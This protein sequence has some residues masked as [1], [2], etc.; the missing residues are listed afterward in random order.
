LRHRGYDAVS[1]DTKL[2]QAGK[3]VTGSTT[4]DGNEVRKVEIELTGEACHAAVGSLNYPSKP[5]HTGPMVVTQFFWSGSIYAASPVSVDIS[6]GPD[7]ARANY[8]PAAVLWAVQAENLSFSG[9]PPFPQK[10]AAGN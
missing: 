5:D 9:S 1:G 8:K 10:L 7:H 4:V 3:T 6:V 2:E